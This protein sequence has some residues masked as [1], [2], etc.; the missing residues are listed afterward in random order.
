MKRTIQKIIASAEAANTGEA[1]TTKLLADNREYIADEPIGLG[2]DDLGASPAQY[3]CMA[4]ASCKAIT[5]RMYA[6]RKNWIVE[7]IRV[8]VSMVRGD[9]MAS[10]A[11]TF[12][13]SIKLVGTLTDEQQ[14]RMLEIA[15]VCP[16]DK[17]LRKPS[18]VVTLIE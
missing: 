16:V 2:G 1:Y 18:E 7:E 15:K 11:N 9:E 12:F 13:C 17:L 6:N 14:K 4:L 10:G 5:L 3:L 8:K